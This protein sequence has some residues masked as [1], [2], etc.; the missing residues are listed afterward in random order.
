MAKT[1]LLVDYDPQSID[2]IRRW[3]AILGVRTIL[4]TDGEAAEREFHRTLPD[5]TLIQDIL[6]KKSGIDVCRTLKDTPSG[7]L[8]P[9]VLLAFARNGAHSRLMAS[10]CDD[11]IEKPFE[12]TTLLAKVRKLLP[13]LTSG[14]SRF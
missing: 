10:G 13:G 14:V 4:A 2:S 6:P 11:W 1:V 8:H 12:A 3:L 7:A 5:L 9:I